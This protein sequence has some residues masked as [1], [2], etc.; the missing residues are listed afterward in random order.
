MNVTLYPLEK[1]T[2]G[3]RSIPFGMER[4]QVEYLLGSGKSQQDD[5]GYAEAV[6]SDDFARS[7]APEQTGTAHRSQ[8]EQEGPS[9]YFAGELSIHYD[10]RQRLEF[11][12]VMGGADSA[13][14]QKWQS[15]AQQG[16]LRRRLPAAHWIS[17]GVGVR[18]YDQPCL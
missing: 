7:L 5:S 13:L 10:N 2:V 16:L 3:G 11:I 6:C 14:R 4:P 9:F 1:V 12:E 17:I 15:Y 8:P 18:G